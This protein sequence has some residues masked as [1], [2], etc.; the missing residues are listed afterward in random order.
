MLIKRLIENT[1]ETHPDLPYLQ[2]YILS[3]LDNGCLE[4]SQ[5]DS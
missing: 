2:V 1:P 5:G 3:P 4:S